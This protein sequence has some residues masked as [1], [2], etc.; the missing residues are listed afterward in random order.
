MF[1]DSP[2]VAP[3]LTVAFM[4]PSRVGMGGFEINS[5]IW[6]ADRTLG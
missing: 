2:L 5:L 6:L 3:M 4:G 1:V